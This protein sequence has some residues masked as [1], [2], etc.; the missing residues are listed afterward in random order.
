MLDVKFSGIPQSIRCE[1]KNLEKIGVTA[2]ATV[3]FVLF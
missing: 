2:G 1:A 3:F